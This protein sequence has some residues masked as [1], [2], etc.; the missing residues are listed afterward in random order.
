MVGS[1]YQQVMIFLWCEAISLLLWTRFCSSIAVLAGAATGRPRELL[2]QRGAE[3]VPL[4][5]SGAD[6]SLL[7]RIDHARGYQ[8]PRWAPGPLASMAMGREESTGG[9][10]R[11]T[12][13]QWVC[14]H[15]G[16]PGYGN[17]SRCH[18][19]GSASALR[20]V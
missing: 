4:G 12:G 10:Q 9:P 17:D 1:K 6:R 20:P 5:N 7:G 19:P 3:Q 8:C 14:G 11:H 18:Y 15:L 2:L 13:L 16:S